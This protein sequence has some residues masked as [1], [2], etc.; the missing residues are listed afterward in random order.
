MQTTIAFIVTLSSIIGIMGFFTNRIVFLIGGVIAFLGFSLY[1]LI[2]V[3][4]RYKLKMIEDAKK[5]KTEKE[6]NAIIKQYKLVQFFS[7]LIVIIIFLIVFFFFKINGI[8]WIGIV[9]GLLYI[10]GIIKIVSKK[11]LKLS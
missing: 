7:S 2:F 6:K 11:I 1:G 3:K 10:P 4:D 5:A 8:S 9:F